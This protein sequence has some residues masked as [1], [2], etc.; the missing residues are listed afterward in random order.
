M[1]TIQGTEWTKGPDF[2]PY[3]R[4]TYAVQDCL[5]AAVSPASYEYIYVSKTLRW[6]TAS[7]SLRLKP[8]R[9]S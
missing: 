2:N 1:F 3:V 5:N 7:R 8:S 6:T 4:F 9:I